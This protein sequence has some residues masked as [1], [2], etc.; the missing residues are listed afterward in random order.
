MD[1]DRLGAEPPWRGLVDGS[2]VIRA[3]FQRDGYRQPLE[4]EQDGAGA[5][6]VRWGE[7][8]IGR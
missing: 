3:W 4:V 1:D 6:D 2:L 5:T 8:A 7:I